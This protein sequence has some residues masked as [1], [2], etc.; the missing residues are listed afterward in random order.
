MRLDACCRGPASGD[1]IVHSHSSTAPFTLSI[2]KNA[3]GAGCRSSGS[4]SSR[5]SLAGAPKLPMTAQ[6]G[7]GGGLEKWGPARPGQHG[8]RRPPHPQLSAKVAGERNRTPALVFVLDVKWV[9]RPN[10]G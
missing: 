5:L 2:L 6:H 3:P 4:G 10:N 8:R 7:A 1:H 9:L